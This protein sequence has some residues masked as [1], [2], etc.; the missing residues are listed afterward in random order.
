MAEVAF[1]AAPLTGGARTDSGDGTAA[2]GAAFLDRP[3][4][5]FAG[6][7]GCSSFSSGC[8]AFVMAEVAFLAAPLTGG[9]RT[10][11]GDGTAAAAGVAFLDR[12]DEEAGFFAGGGW[13]SSSSS[14]DCSAF[15]F[16]F[17]HQS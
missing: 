13:S 12:A 8:S 3:A 4:G 10:E 14:S 2:A 17:L 11:S 5:F 9:A 16:R 7:G 6:A 1:L 15:C